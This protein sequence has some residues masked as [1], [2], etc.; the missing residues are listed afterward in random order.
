MR[1]LT[2]WDTSSGHNREYLVH[3]DTAMQNRRTVLWEFPKIPTSEIC[4]FAES[5]V[6]KR[7][8]GVVLAVLDGEPAELR[9]AVTCDADWHTTDAVVDLRSDMRT[10][11]WQ[12]AVRGGSW[13][14]NGAV[15]AEFQ[16]LID[17]DLGFSP[18]TNTL[19]IRRLHLQ[20]GEQSSFTAVWL[21]FPELRFERLDQKYTR[22]AGQRYRYESGGGTFTAEL[23]VDELGLVTTY[24]DYWKRRSA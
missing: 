13:T 1:R 24:G 23:A 7:F 17:I 20:K 6:V 12:I 15:L 9:Y 21:R 18:C 22:L 3:R 4:R 8:D 10:D 2:G 5:D 19:P 16:G 14:C 11:H